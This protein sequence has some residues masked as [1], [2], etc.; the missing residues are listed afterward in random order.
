MLAAAVSGYANAQESM[1][2]DRRNGERYERTRAALAGLAG[3]LGAVRQAV[4]GGNQKAL[5]EFVAAVN[6]QVSLEHRQWLEGAAAAKE[7]TARL[8]EALSAM[9]HPKNEKKDG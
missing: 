9:S 3:R 5:A 1:S 6:D 4:R 7:A 2:Q 8:D